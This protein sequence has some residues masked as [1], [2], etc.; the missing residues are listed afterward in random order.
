[1]KGA[2]CG[3]RIFKKCVGQAWDGKHGCPYWQEMLVTIQEGKT[4]Y[5]VVR[6]QCI[7]LWMYDLGWWSHN[8]LSGV[9]Q[10]T[11]SFRN[12]M[13]EPYEPEAGKIS[14]RPKPDAAIM[15][16]LSMAANP[17]RQLPG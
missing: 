11:E 16:I 12:G 1:M 10:A 5:E 7:E 13:L 2:P 3:K 8:R 6:G 4:K 15:K 17:Q 14:F 9:Q